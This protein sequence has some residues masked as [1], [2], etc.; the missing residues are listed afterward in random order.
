MLFGP[1]ESIEAPTEEMIEAVVEPEIE[2]VRTEVELEDSA[3]NHN[4]EEIKYDTIKDVQALEQDQP[5]GAK[6]AEI[7]VE[8]PSVQPD[9]DDSSDILFFNMSYEE[10]ERYQ[11]AKTKELE[12]IFRDLQRVYSQ[13]SSSSVPP[14]ETSKPKE[15][16]ISSETR[17]ASYFVPP[18]ALFSVPPSKSGSYNPLL[19]SEP[20]S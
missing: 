4:T 8:T 20:I 6:S 9:E 1:T 17:G 13:P 11:Q 7:P 15:E 5:S 14:I 18:E 12:K 16:A 3:I 2:E 10:F 19:V